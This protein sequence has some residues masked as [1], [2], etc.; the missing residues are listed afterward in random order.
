MDEKA[1]TR[2]KEEVIAE[3]EAALAKKLAEMRHRKRE[4]VDPVQ[5]AVSVGAP[6]LVDYRPALPAESAPPTA[7]QIAALSK[8]G[9]FPGDVQHAGLAEAILSTVAH[10][11]AGGYASPKQVR[12]LEMYGWTRAGQMTYAAAQKVISRIAA[13]GWRVPAGLVPEQRLK[14]EI[15]TMRDES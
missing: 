10:R 8:A 14:E 15:S 11:K 5:Y 1:L 3:R 9:I 4:L 13:N 6:G 12:R 7:A 2:A